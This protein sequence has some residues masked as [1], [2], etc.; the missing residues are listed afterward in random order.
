MAY[1]KSIGEL[2]EFIRD[3]HT[4]NKLLM[5]LMDNE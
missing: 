2:E 1:V 5:V 3:D 4:K